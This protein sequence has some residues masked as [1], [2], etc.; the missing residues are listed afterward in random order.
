MKNTA[1]FQRAGSSRRLTG[2]CRRPGF[3]M[4][5]LAAIVAMLCATLAPL[6]AAAAYPDKPI[7]ILCWSK[8]GSSVDLYSRTLAE[9]TAKILGQPLVV[10]TKTG[11]GGVVASNALMAKPANGYTLLAVTRTLTTKFGEPGVQFKPDDFRPIVRSILDPIVI[12]VPG[13]SQFKTIQDFIKYGKANPG[14]LKVAGSFALGLHRVAWEGF[15]K[16]T[17]I[18]AVWVPYQGSAPAAAAVAG[19]HVSAAAMNPGVVR[20]QVAA[21]KIRILATASDKRLADYPNVPTLKD[22]GIDYTAYQWRGVMAKAGTS[23]AIVDKLAK[24]FQQAQQTP[25]WKAFLKKMSWLDGYEGPQ[26]FENDFMSAIKQMDALKA[27]LKL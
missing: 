15:A 10:E 20:A 2:R 27:K 19:G 6:P 26:G 4:A 9:L 12:M 14:K 18:T 25:E 16:K 17:G 11:G 23:K 1:R 21:G 8:P 5:G 3:L 13:D 22:V 24:A 7:K